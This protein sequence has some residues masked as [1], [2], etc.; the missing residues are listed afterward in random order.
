MVVLIALGLIVSMLA[1]SLR[2]RKISS[3]IPA[4]WN[5]GFGALTTE[6]FLS[7]GLP[8]D[9]PVG[10]VTNVLVANSPQLIFSLL[11]T[12][13]RAMLSC[14]L[15]QDEFSRMGSRRKPLRVTEPEGIQRSSYFISLPFRYGIPLNVS[16]GILHWSVSQSIFLARVTAFFPNG[17][18]DY[19]SSFS[20]CS[21]SLIAMFISKSTLTPV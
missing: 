12:F 14:L 20:T 9:D 10:L 11:Y 7:I 4:L 17:D 18:V 8:K 19:G 16:A 1:A 21:H 6:T 3:S 2:Y 15:V 5:L 13:S